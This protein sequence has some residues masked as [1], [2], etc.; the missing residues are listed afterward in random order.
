VKENMKR[1]NI[2]T[3]INSITV[4]TGLTLVLVSCTQPKIPVPQDN[5]PAATIISSPTN[6]ADKIATILP[7]LTEVAAPLSTQISPGVRPV[8]ISVNEHDNRIYIANNDSKNITVI[9]GLNNV[10]EATINIETNN[11]I[12]DSVA[13]RLYTSD[14]SVID[15][16]TFRNIGKTA[17]GKNRAINIV[18][19]RLYVGDDNKAVISVIDLDSLKLVT[20]I[21]M[22][23]ILAVDEKINR[24]YIVRNNKISVIDGKTNAFI[25]DII[26]DQY[27]SELTVNASLNRVYAQTPQA[28]D[29]VDG[30]NNK[31]L[32]QLCYAFTSSVAFNSKSGTLYITTENGL[33]ILDIKSNDLVT[34]IPFETNQADPKVAVNTKLE[35][36]YVTQP[37]SDRIIV[38]NTK[39]NST[40]GFIPIGKAQSWRLEVP[41]IGISTRIPLYS[42]PS[43]C[44]GPI[45]IEANSNTDRTYVL[46]WSTHNVAVLDSNSGRLIATIAVEAGPNDIAVDPFS[47][48]VYVS[49]G[50]SHSINIIDC[51]KNTVVGR[52]SLPGGPSSLAI[53]SGNRLLVNMGRSISVYDTQSL[54]EVARIKVDQGSNDLCVDTTTNRIYARGDRNI[55]VI[56][57][58]TNNII[59]TIN[60][61]SAARLT[62]NPKENQIY[63]CNYGGIAIISTQTFQVIGNI[64]VG[65]SGSLPGSLV[66]NKDNSEMYFC[67]DRNLA[68][69]DCK[70]MKLVR[71]TPVVPTTWNSFNWGIGNPMLAI[72]KAS[73]TLFYS[74]SS[75]DSVFIVDASTSNVKKTVNI[76]SV[77][78]G[79]ATN[80]KTNKIYISNGDTNTVSVIDSNTLE[81]IKNI[82]VGV[83]PTEI[84]LNESTNLI[85]VATE[86]SVYVIDGATNSVV[87]I[88]KVRRFPVINIALNPSTNLLYVTVGRGEG[89]LEVVDTKTNAIIGSSIS[90]I[91]CGCLA[92]NPKSNMLY[93]N[94]SLNSG[95]MPIED[96]METTPSGIRM[97]YRLETYSGL[98]MGGVSIFDG[99]NS[100][101]SKSKS[102]VYSKDVPRGRIPIVI[103]SK[104]NYVYVGPSSISSI[105]KSVK[106]G[107]LLLIAGDVSS[108][109]QSLSIQGMSN[110]GFQDL[111]INEE[112]STLYILQENG[113]LLILDEKSQK[114]LGTLQTDAGNVS[115]RIIANSKT[116]SVYVMNHDRGTL[117]VVKL[118]K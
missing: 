13:N 114:I 26:I 71:M 16:K 35:R 39:D 61:T 20:T 79:I 118:Q 68:T 104:L 101:L 53:G 76:G 66:I 62:V 19:R 31:F 36:A 92:V 98:L 24:I 44:V 4:L 117:S 6:N 113:V 49:N 43:N 97:Y 8:A 1:L 55:Y 47:N 11:I 106:S 46:C 80:I 3:L 91:N 15:G 59:K 17:P 111:S 93:V 63:A 45:A 83:C 28:I 9:D 100:T 41:N 86:T 102:L 54:L 116:N 2:S 23:G 18:S 10:V 75:V 81:I 12:I 115:E 34:T 27:V 112:T 72:N 110:S 74:C 22:A 69:I 67:V 94:E 56:D 87:N 25:E 109:I 30:L 42:G 50:I 85:Y 78:N 103:D 60:Q 84:V 77:P 99:T 107:Q 89:S 70:N 29:L 105:A 14:G 32:A 37:N 88:I 58:N 65:S 52:I 7:T 40:I 64:T 33:T 90:I 57:G 51:D 73:N 48:K 95:G 5:T 21:N 38:I 108:G 96:H 82:D